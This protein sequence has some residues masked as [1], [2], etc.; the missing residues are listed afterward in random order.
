MCPQILCGPGAAD[1]LRR[2]LSELLSA[3]PKN[4]APRAL[5][6]IL[7]ILRHSA[8]EFGVSTALELRSRLLERCRALESGTAQGHQRPDIRSRRP[9]LYLN[10]D[11][12]PFLIAY[13]VKTKLIS[14]VVDGRMGFGRDG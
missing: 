10:T 4:L 5:Q 11:P 3:F 2:P 13:D 12:Y 1:A 8:K 14:A 6:Q 7:V 9:M